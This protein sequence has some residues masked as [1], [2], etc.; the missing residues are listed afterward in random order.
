MHIIKQN[1]CK[2]V[3][4]LNFLLNATAYILSLNEAKEKGQKGK[5]TKVYTIFG[6][7]KH[8]KFMLYLSIPN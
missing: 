2:T 3:K 6:R 5:K 4:T 7:I 1:I 8:K